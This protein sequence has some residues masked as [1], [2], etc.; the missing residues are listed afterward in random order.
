MGFGVETVL[1]N[2]D[3]ECFWA[4]Q[5]LNEVKGHVMW[6]SGG[7]ILH[8]EGTASAKAL[9]QEKLGQDEQELVVGVAG[10]A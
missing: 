4:K 7:S 8:A 1:N 3:R 6:V 2:V 5:D 9:Q 10:V